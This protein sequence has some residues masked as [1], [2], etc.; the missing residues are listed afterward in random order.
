MQLNS[1]FSFAIRR[2]FRW[3]NV[4]R[5]FFRGFFLKTGLSSLIFS[6]TVCHPLLAC[7]H[8]LSNTREVRFSHLYLTTW[9]TKLTC[10]LR[11]QL[12][13]LCHKFSSVLNFCNFFW[14]PQMWATAKKNS[15]SVDHKAI[16][17]TKHRW[18]LKDDT[19]TSHLQ[20]EGTRDIIYYASL[21]YPYY[22]LVIYAQAEYKSYSLGPNNILNQICI[23]S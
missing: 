8:F 23:T 11:I 7:L 12:I 14:L 6:A 22:P 5:Y 15:K 1:I 2:L 20:Y 3:I 19:S 10:H 21:N 13:P 17:S 16:N 4:Y 9:Y 18:V